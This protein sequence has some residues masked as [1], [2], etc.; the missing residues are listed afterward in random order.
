M[1]DEICEM[2]PCTCR[3]EEYLPV[4]PVLLASVVTPF[5]GGPPPVLGIRDPLGRNPGIFTVVLTRL[6][7]FAWTSSM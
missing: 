6:I 1:P 7:S 5:A 4:V 3:R 2:D